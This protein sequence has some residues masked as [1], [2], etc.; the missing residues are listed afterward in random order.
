MKEP[1]DMFRSLRRNIVSSGA[2]ILAAGW[3]LAA[4]SGAPETITIHEAPAAVQTHGLSEVTSSVADKQIAS[5]PATGHEAPESAAVERAEQ[6]AEASETA[7]RFAAAAAAGARQDAMTLAA[8]REAP[9]SLSA[10]KE[11]H[12]FRAGEI[13][14][15]GGPADIRAIAG[16]GLNIVDRE[17]LPGLGAFLLRVSIPLSIDR[18]AFEA[19]MAM[20]FPKA[21][22]DSNHI[23]RLANSTPGAL[24]GQTP[25]TPILTPGPITTAAWWA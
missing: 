6:R 14:I 21:S 1:R 13:V 12:E 23:Y 10:D 8:I 25:G 5:T 7:A 17:P 3:P 22:V 19:K 16:M 4:A 24:P 15:V 18:D 2:L 11:G 9:L 20:G